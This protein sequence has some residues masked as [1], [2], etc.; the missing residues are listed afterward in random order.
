MLSRYAA[1][2]AAAM[3]ARQKVGAT[4]VSSNILL[5]SPTG[6]LAS[7]LL[8]GLRATSA[9]AGR[10]I[11][12]GVRPASSM[13]PASTVAMR[14]LSSLSITR[15]IAFDDTFGRNSNPLRYSGAFHHNLRLQSRGFS[16]GPPGGF[17]GQSQPWVNPD[18]QVPGQNLEQYGVD[19]TKMAKDGK[20]DPV[21]G[22][23]DEIRRTSQILARRTKNNPVLIGEPGV[24][25]TAIA[26][27]LAQR[28]VSG[29]VPES[30]KDK[31]VISLDL[32]QLLAGAMFR[33]QF[34][35]RLKGIIKDIEASD[36]DVILFIDELHTIIG[37][38]KGEGSM[39]MSNMLKPSLARGE[40]QLVGA[41]TLDEYRQ[42]EKDAALAR[43]FQSVYIAEPSVEDTVS[44]L[45]GLKGSYELHHGIRIKDEALI[46]AAT[47][48]DRYL[49]DRK[50]PDKSIDLVDEACSRLRLEQESKPEIIWKV[51]RDLLTKQIELSALANEDD[52]K[53]SVARRAQVKEEVDVL[54]ARLKELTDVWQ[55]ERDELERGKKLQEEI[56]SARRELTKARRDGDFNRAGELQHMTIPRLEQEMEELERKNEEAESNGEDAGNKMLA[57]A[58]TA[59]AIATIVARHTGI[60]VSRNTGSESRKLLHMEE[61]LRE[62]VVGQDH[63]LPAV[64]N[65]VRLAR[66]RLQAQDRTLGNFLFLGPTGVGKTELCKSL[67]SF[68][69]EDESAMTRIDMSEYGEKHTVSRLIGAPPGYVGYEEG[70][71]LTEAV[72]RRPYQVILLDEFEK[73]HRDVWNLLLQLFDDGRLT[74]SHGRVVNFQNCIVVMTSN[75]G[76]EVLAN[77]P[78][79]MTGS[80]PEVQN[81]VM[82]V[83]RH[84]LSP[85]LLNRIDEVCHFNRLQRE[86]MDRIAEIGIDDIAQRLEKGQNMEL[87]VTP[88]A[89]N[90]LA[91]KGYDV[92]Y[93]AR[94]LKRALA[95]DLLNPLSRLVLEGGVIDGDTVRVRTRAQGEQLIDAG[96]NNFG[97]ITSSPD[98]DED[99]VVIMRNHEMTAEDQ[100]AEDTWDDDEFLMEDGT[101]HHP[102]FRLFDLIS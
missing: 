79:T 48:S 68:I 2:R 92:R 19:L 70:G 53:K 42:I 31:R 94:P 7:R 88:E 22:R 78:D 14:P 69:F 38:G 64:S 90:C 96:D 25:K 67:A 81:A 11:D 71:V 99:A 35:E 100:G 93:G 86:H 58:V 97:Y 46:A 40:L 32:A 59:Q 102:M 33:G 101:H 74:D 95:R 10:G 8:D 91:N 36:G 54:N 23:H 47:L 6:T 60:P 83:V 72:R 17:S 37:A 44:I 39:D 52:D 26:E 4:V 9:S 65:C 84:T 76:A 56:E 80:E 49:S 1:G 55:A 3:K 15:P 82:E 66:T 77:M 73:G 63:A 62:R 16:S 27:G 89:I 51:E 21:I 87:D 50:Q 13:T 61:K 20:L 18:A 24:G 45:R 12:G 28:I 57:D 34:E 85:E 29:E 98:D 41:T 43:R 5:V 30:M 75:M